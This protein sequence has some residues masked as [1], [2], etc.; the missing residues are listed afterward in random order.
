MFHKKGET[1]YMYSKYTLFACMWMK[2]LW[3]YTCKPRTVVVSGRGTGNLGDWMGED[4]LYILSYVFIKIL[5][6]NIF[7]PLSNVHF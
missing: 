7:H 6:G 2:Y 5:T 3:K 4:F 1:E